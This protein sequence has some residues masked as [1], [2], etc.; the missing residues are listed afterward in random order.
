MARNNDHLMQVLYEKID[1][2]KGI[3]RTE[4]LINFRT[5]VKRNPPVF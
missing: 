3:V 4:T 2:I 1:A 5:V